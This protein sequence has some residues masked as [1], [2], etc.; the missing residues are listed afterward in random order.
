MFQVTRR[1]E[2]IELGEN[3]ISPEAGPQP[4]GTEP[5]PQPTK[6]V[7][8]LQSSASSVSPR[9]QDRQLDIPETSTSRVRAEDVM[10]PYSIL[11]GL[12]IF[13]IFVISFVIVMVVR[14]VVHDAPI[15]FKFFA[16]MYLAG[17]YLA[18]FSC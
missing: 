18:V 15:L 6:L 4:A 5:E 10:I 12:I 14:G 2:T 9:P 3:P 17:I 8:N 1:Q 13:G 16:N 7:S 11:T